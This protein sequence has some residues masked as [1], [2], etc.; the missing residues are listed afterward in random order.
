MKPKSIKLEGW[1]GG[2]EVRQWQM[3]VRN[4]TNWQ[5]HVMWPPAHWHQDSQMCLGKTFST[6]F[7]LQPPEKNSHLFFL[8][9]FAIFCS[10]I[11]PLHIQ[12]LRDLQVFALHKQSGLILYKYNFHFP[13]EEFHSLHHLYLGG[14]M[15]LLVCPR[16]NI[17]LY[18]SIPSCLC[19]YM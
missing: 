8:T 15:S 1:V 13:G 4:L 19:M 6:S 9:W 14:S 3:A 2:W 11:Y 5:T 7:D 10:F 16:V 18:W 17:Q 12:V